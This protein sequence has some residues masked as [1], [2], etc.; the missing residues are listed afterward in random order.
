[1]NALRVFFSRVREH[2]SRGRIDSDFQEELRS[3]LEM[4]TDEHLR[5]GLSP[6]EAHRAAL[7]EIGGFERTRELVGERRG[8]AHLDNLSR[9]VRHALRVLRKAPGFA[10]VAVFTLALGIGANAAIFSFIDAVILR[11]LPYPE[12]DRL[13]AIW[14]MEDGSGERGAVAP[15]NIAD[16][17][18]VSGFAAVASY[19]TVSRS[20]TGGGPPEGHVAE[21]VSHD[22][23]D[24]LRVQP[25]LGRGFTR[26]EDSPTGRKV[27]IISDALWQSR[28]GSD[29]AVLGRPI[30]IDG[31]PH[32]VV[33][34]M[35]PSFR[36]L[37][38][39][40]ARDGRHIWVPA[41]Y[42][43]ELLANRGDHEVNLVGRLRD[44]ADVEAARAEL[45]SL[46]ESLAKAH[47]DTNGEVR[48]GVRPLGDD[49]VRSVRRSLTALMLT[50]GLILAIACVNVANLLIARGVGRRREVA[51]R[52]ALGATRTR[53]YTALVTESVVLALLASIAGLCLAIWMKGL[54]VSVAP[55][56]LPRLSD[57]AL[58]TRVVL[59]TLGLS[60]LTGII[61]G[62]VP[63]WQA[64]Q[65][66]PI[67]AMSSG[68]RIVAGRKI[69]AWRNGLMITQ[70]ALSALLLVGAGL[71]IKSLVKLNR[72]DLGFDTSGVIAIRTT[73]P[74][75]KYPTG[76]ERLAFFAALEDRVAAL[77]GVAG[78]GFTN[79]LPLRGGW[80]SG[81][82]IEGEPEP[83]D[84]YLSAGFQAVSPGYFQT[85]GIPLLR[86]RQI[87]RSD[88]NDG[89][90][91]AIV[92]EAFERVFLG[93]RDAIGRR[94][95]RGPGAPM[96]TVVGVIRDVRRDGRAEVLEPQVYLPASQTS[97]YPVRLSELAVR[98]ASGDPHT[99]VPAI[100]SA[101]WS[102][103]PDQ[104]LTR[105]ST[106]DETLTAQ[107][108]ER[109]FQT[110]LFAIFAAL[111]LV[112]AS[113][114][115]YG[116]VAYL[117]SQRTP[118]IGVRLAL[119]ASR[120][121]IYRW[122]LARTALL[123]VTGALAGI[124]AARLLARFVEALLFEVPGGD[125][126]TYVAAGGTLIVVGLAA[127]LLAGR[128]A[129]RVSPTVALR[130][131]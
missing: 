85:L 82:R 19:T 39:Y 24:V 27:V 26:E 22:Y 108:A 64:G 51:V 8:F 3:N 43:A 119:G 80:G 36:G 86:G 76:V 123:V 106:L 66:N 111:A 90:P 9:D 84:G 55:S 41:A 20:L 33:G 127:C 107:S 59:F 74:P 121:R 91:V 122:L 124:G 87:A 62:G 2:L 34:V 81:F 101:I 88:V 97:L 47:P 40:G 115:T 83:A 58:D 77:P 53:V 17:Q 5:R 31:I 75:A 73:L 18:T 13:V 118:E 125:V 50:V 1:M 78:V 110:L 100:R 29:P 16:Y 32:E 130:Y 70:L 93:G 69:M 128:R 46:S 92:S 38:G 117:V 28:F 72:V 15:A 4:I 54:L 89:Q 79:T 30:S 94:L 68:G 48:A 98:A 126:S 112:L 42:P 95:W 131:E 65:T 44:G 12:P 45:T 37:T 49:L 10:A 25:A 14:E 109:R 56:S 6:D 71:M 21:A 105:V 103:D 102:I 7:L 104:P 57:V 35:P 120:G 60:F 129:S 113:I 99:L 52:Y 67:D 23:F 114:G 96:I 116:V 61:F 11:P 63:A